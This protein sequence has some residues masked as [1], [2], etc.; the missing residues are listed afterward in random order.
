M[1]VVS[2]VILICLVSSTTGYRPVLQFSW[3]P[4][5]HPLVSNGNSYWKQPCLPRSSL[6]GPPSPLLSPVCA[7]DSAATA[8]D[9]TTSAHA[10]QR[11][12]PTPWLPRSRQALYRVRVCWV[13]LQSPKREGLIPSS[14]GTWVQMGNRAAALGGPCP[15]ASLLSP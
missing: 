8:L 10:H 6:P 13:A 11:S 14:G 5:H 4:T 3:S 1:S 7:L 9:P 2:A 15:H 12:A